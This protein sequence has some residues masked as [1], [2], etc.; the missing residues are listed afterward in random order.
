MEAEIARLKAHKEDEA[1]VAEQ[2]HK[3]ALA[4]CVGPGWAGGCAAARAA[5]AQGGAEVSGGR[6]GCVKGWPTYTCAD[7]KIWPPSCS[8]LPAKSPVVLTTVSCSCLIVGVTA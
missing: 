3:E 5:C 2:R 7:E 6:L 4:W 1:R 8:T